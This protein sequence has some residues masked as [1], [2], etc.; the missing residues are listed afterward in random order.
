[1][2]LEPP[3]FIEEADL[4][5]GWGE[6]EWDRWQKLQARLQE[7][8]VKR[9]EKR[10]ADDG[11]AGMLLAYTELVQSAFYEQEPISEGEPILGAVNRLALKLAPP[12]GVNS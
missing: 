3:N 5:E 1:M 2:E 11:G 7:L 12:P 4:A 8:G 9:L 6:Q 10:A